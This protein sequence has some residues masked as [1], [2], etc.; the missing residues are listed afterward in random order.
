MIAIGMNA[1]ANIEPVKDALSIATNSDGL[2]ILDDGRNF[3][4]EHPTAAQIVA[5]TIDPMTTSAMEV[6][7]VA[8]PGT[9]LPLFGI[10]GP[11][12]ILLFLNSTGQ[13]G[14]LLGPDHF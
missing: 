13:P 6:C 14:V 2:L 8:E 10:R 12:P 9:N 11:P 3:E 5:K 1:S 7:S 4:R